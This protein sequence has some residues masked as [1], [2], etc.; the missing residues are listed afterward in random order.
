MSPH[1]RRDVL[2]LGSL[3]LGASLAGCLGDVPLVGTADLGPP[4]RTDGRGYTSFEFSLDGEPL[5]SLG[6]LYRTGYRQETGR[7]RFELEAWHADGTHLDSIGYHVHMP[8]E[9]DVY[10]EYYLRT[11]GGFPWPNLHF[12]H[13]RNGEG[14]HLDV[15]DL[16]FQGTGTVRFKL[17]ADVHEEPSNL[18]E[19]IPLSVD[20]ELV[21]TEKGIASRDYRAR[22]DGVSEIERNPEQ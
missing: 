15:P 4:E 7:V 6:V 20:A 18:P 21:L 1:S 9:G 14:I 5:L 10:V 11:P 2:R 22:A 16:E 12:Q 13:D 19:T 8:I 17:I 3:G